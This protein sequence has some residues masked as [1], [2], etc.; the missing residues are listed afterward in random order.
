MK[1][2]TNDHGYPVGWCAECRFVQAK[3]YFLDDDNKNG[4]CIDCF[5]KIVELK[6]AE[7]RAKEILGN[8]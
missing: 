8:K 3:L 4:Y 5:P 1:T 7:K 2:I 6:I